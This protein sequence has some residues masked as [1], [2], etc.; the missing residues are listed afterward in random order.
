MFDFDT[1]W[2]ANSCML[3][4]SYIYVSYTVNSGYWQVVTIYK[5]PVLCWPWLE[6]ETPAPKL[7]TFWVPVELD[8]DKLAFLGLQKN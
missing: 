4:F 7:Y 8:R 3:L 2:E 6:L 5:S 1:E